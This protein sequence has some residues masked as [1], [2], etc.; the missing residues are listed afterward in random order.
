MPLLSCFRRRQATPPPSPPAAPTQ[1]SFASSQRLPTVTNGF[2]PASVAELHPEYA[3]AEPYHFAART[4]SARLVLE[5]SSGATAALRTPPALAAF[6]LGPPP[7][8]AAAAPPP[9]LVEE[10]AASNAALAQKVADEKEDHRRA[11]KAA[12][13]AASAS[14]ENDENSGDRVFKSASP[15][16]AS[17]RAPPPARASPHAPPPARVPLAQAVDINA[18]AAA[19]VAAQAPARRKSIRK[20]V[21]FREEKPEIIDADYAFDDDEDELTP[22]ATPPHAPHTPHTPPRLSMPAFDAPSP[23]HVAPPAYTSPRPTPPPPREIVHTTPE[24]VAAPVA[25]RVESV[26]PAASKKRQ[27][28]AVRNAL[29]QQ[30]RGVPRSAMLAY[31]ENDVEKEGSGHMSR[32]ASTV[33]PFNDGWFDED[34]VGSLPS[35]KASGD[36]NR[37]I[38]QRNRSRSTKS[39]RLPPQVVP[40]VVP[41]PPPPPPF[42][43]AAARMRSV[44]MVG[45]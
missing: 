26:D 3:H 21:S 36:S 35:L 27:S 9:A 29:S 23:D 33:A 31:A 25:R 32:A 15:A 7:L 11:K 40:G 24:G 19:P 4:E 30:I 45:R 20:T 44:R 16:R 38:G 12:K 39:I 18:L 5:S 37:S 22:P 10:D 41:R 43:P 6:G 14:K 42:E 2:V 13:R 34:S 17:S 28:M 1:S 8:P